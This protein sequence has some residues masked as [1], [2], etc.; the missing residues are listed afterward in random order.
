MPRKLYDK[1]QEK[2]L[3]QPIPEGC[4]DIARTLGLKPEDTVWDYNLVY[5]AE[6]G[7]KLTDTHMGIGHEGIT[8]LIRGGVQGLTLKLHDGLL[9]YQKKYLGTGN[10]TEVTDK[11]HKNDLFHYPEQSVIHQLAQKVQKEP[12][13]KEIFNNKV[14]CSLMP[15]PDVQQGVAALGGKTLISGEEAIAFNSKARVVTDAETH[16]YNV[17]PFVIAYSEDDIDKTIDALKDKAKALELDPEKTPYWIKFDHFGAGMGVR[18][19]DP[20]TTSVDEIK[21]WIK[22]TMKEAEIP[23][24]K[25]TPVVM[26]ID[27]G[28]LPEV[29]EIVVNLNV[30][31][32]VSDTGVSVTGVTFQKTVDGHYLGGRLPL[33][34]EEKGFASEGMSWALPVLK[35]AQQ[36]GYRGYAGIDLILAREPSGA[37]RGYVLEMNGRINSSTSLLATSQWV[38]KQ[39]GLKNVAASNFT[40]TFPSLKDF[41]SFKKEFNSVLYKG[42]STDYT[43]IIPI[44]LKPDAEGNIHGV[45]TIAI[46]PD[47]ESL[48]KLEKRYEAIVKKL[49]K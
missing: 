15:A 45:K 3:L 25:F 44:I 16:R 42:R 21:A 47:A 24:G 37:L 28:H 43:G 30:Q 31:A 49:Q 23:A 33:T 19:Y 35:A 22:E 20:Q 29:K 40:S 26:D 10:V 2:P 6:G 41:K 18:S 38:A 36:Q 48:A 14:F 1:P 27:I 7:M 11:R 13:L 46:A 12:R 39:A 5:S 32:I 8:P 17:A 9:E 34:D 4:A